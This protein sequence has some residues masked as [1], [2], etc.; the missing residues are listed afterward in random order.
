MVHIQNIKQ[1]NFF[2]FNYVE[3]LHR[4]ILGH[5]NISLFST[6]FLVI[7]QL[8]CPVIYMMAKKY[9]KA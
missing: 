1:T 6:T 3:N 8:F 4:N 2:Y 7:F 5:I 9:Q